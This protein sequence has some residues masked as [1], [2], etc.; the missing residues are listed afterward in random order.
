VR[1][2]EPGALRNPIIL[3]GDVAEPINPPSVCLFHTPLPYCSSFD[4]CRIEEAGAA[5]QRRTVRGRGRVSRSAATT[6]GPFGLHVSGAAVSG[7]KLQG[8]WIAASSTDADYGNYRRSLRKES[9]S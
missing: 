7:D 1:S 4:R 8:P 5:E 2:R 9:C 6:P 3:K